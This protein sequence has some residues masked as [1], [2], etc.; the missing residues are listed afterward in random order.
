MK[1]RLIIF[2]SISF[3]FFFNGNKTPGENET[4]IYLNK[5]YPVNERVDDLLK[6]L[7]LEE[8]IDLLSGT[9]FAT[10]PVERLGIPELRMADGPVGVRWEKSNSYPSGISMAATWNPDLI[11]EIGAAIAQ[12]T[13]A[14]GRD[15]ILGP[16]VNILR[17]PHG[18]RNFESFGEDPYLTSRITVGYIKGVQKENV[19]ACVKHFACNNQEFQRDFVDVKVDERA[20]NE[21]YLP[22]F[23]AAVLEADV[24]SIMSAYNKVNGQYCSENDYL[25][26]EK[27]KREW[28]F[29]GLVMSDWGAV[30]SSVPT[31]K[32]G[33][34]LEMPTGQWLNRNTLLGAVNSGELEESVINDKVKRIL[35]V[36]IKLGLMDKQTQP[37]TSSILNNNKSRIA[38]QTALESIVL[39]KNDNNILPITDRI[40]SIAVIGPSANIS[41]T[42]GGGSSFVEP[43]YSISPLEGLRNRNGGKMKISFAKGIVM[44]GDADPINKE[45]LPGGLKAEFFN[46]LNL[47]GKPVLTRTDEMV[48]FWWNGKPDERVN[49]DVFSVRWTG[50]VKAPQSGEYIFDITSDDGIRFY[51]EDQ[52]LIEDWND[53]AFLT[54]SVKVKMVKGKTYKIKLEYYENRGAAVVTIGWRLP[55]NNLMAE[56]IRIAK[57]SDLALVF[58]G[59]T[60]NDESE[61]T[62]RPDLEL[63]ND[64]SQLIAEIIKVNKNTIVILNN[65][66]PVLVNK[67]IDNVPALLET[68]FYG[69]EGGNAIADVLL[70]NYNPSGRLPFSWPRKWEDCSAYK[71][72]KAMD[73]TTYYDDGIYVGYRHYEKKHIEPQ[74]PF[75]FGKSYT[76]FAYENL[77]IK[78]GDNIK[79]SFTLIN[80]GSIKGEETAQLYVRDVES[81]VDRPVKELKGFSKVLLEPGE[82]KLITLE[83]TKD[84]LSFYDV[85]TKSWIAEPGEFE[86]LVGSSSADIKLR[87]IFRF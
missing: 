58:A 28:G 34:D 44:Q 16:C 84:D 39:L 63:P 62:D 85:K 83:L 75:G 60:S 59:T 10:K 36:I 64:Q 55:D 18:G 14:K 9:G 31:A 54:N 37:D 69:Q 66:G 57:E 80:T 13:K 4:E 5:N 49:E 82:K 38:Y 53:H 86:I 29:N 43:I 24:M 78:R 35:T 17:V 67:W 52:L 42:G 2:L 23:K 1:K 6:K 41:R 65:G 87:E 50:I 33:L 40:K 19:A 8:K 7:T 15:L 20:L 51:F 76:R 47:E 25:L 21:I 12:D 68:W 45:Y 70:G 56:A 71:T 79:V 30:H 73:S 77:K 72:Y 22:A 11:S 27:L 48:N 26:T 81:S 32:R 74:F 46:N 61:G 3:I